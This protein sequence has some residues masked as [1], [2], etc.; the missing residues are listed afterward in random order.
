MLLI[1][2]LIET[3]FASEGIIDALSYCFSQ[4]RS[5]SKPQGIIWLR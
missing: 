2:P 1:T 5:G 4:K 3:F